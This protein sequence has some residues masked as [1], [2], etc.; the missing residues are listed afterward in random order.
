MKLWIARDEGDNTCKIFLKEPYKVYD[1][2]I[3]KYCWET[4]DMMGTYMCLPSS[5][6]PEVTFEN[7]PQEVELKL[8]KEWI[9]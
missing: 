5:E 8:I 4:S 9:L 6:F 3:K 7:S 1:D 2:F